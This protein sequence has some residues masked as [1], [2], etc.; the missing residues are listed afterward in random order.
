MKHLLYL[1]IAT[2]IFLSSCKED[3]DQEV[4]FIIETNLGNMKGKLYNSTPKHRD[5]FMK[6][7]NDKYYHDL[8]FH[9]VI[10]GFMIQGGDP[11]SKLAEPQD[12]LGGGGPGYTIEAEFDTNYIHKRGALAAARLG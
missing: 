10:K 12:Q 7:V 6:L 9:R 1:I 3:M 2:T 4:E 11:D 5:N 8:L